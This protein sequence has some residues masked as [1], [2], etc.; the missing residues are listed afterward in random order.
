MADLDDAIAA[1]EQSL[2]ALYALQTKA[3]TSGDLVT[4]KAL[5]DDIDGLTYKL[6]QLQS[7]QIAGEDQQIDALNTQLGT[8]TASAQGALNDLSKLSSV[9]QGVVKASQIIDGIVSAAIK[10]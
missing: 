5:E 4:Q 10:A 3:M 6:T 2:Q 1:G 9:L 8:V 7:Q